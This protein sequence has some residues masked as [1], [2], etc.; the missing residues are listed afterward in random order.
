VLADGTYAAIVVD[1]SPGDDGSVTLDLAIASGE[2]KGD[3]VRVVDRTS[4]G[5]PLDRLALPVTLKIASGQPTV[6]FDP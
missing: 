4:V 6:T 3:V 5:E 1:A 2:H